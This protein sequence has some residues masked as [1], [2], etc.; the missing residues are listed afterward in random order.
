MKVFNFHLI[1][2]YLNSANMILYKKVKDK[3]GKLEMAKES[4][5]RSFVNKGIGVGTMF[6]SLVKRLAESNNHMLIN[7]DYS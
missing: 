5:I 3:V 1:H 4:E 2:I 6:N 7:P